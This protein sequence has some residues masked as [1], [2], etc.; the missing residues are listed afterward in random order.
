MN[1]DA[2]R[3]DH[4]AAPAPAVASSAIAIIGMAGAMPG[5]LD[6]AAYWSHLLAGDD[7]VTEVPAD[8]WDWRD[9]DGDPLGDGNRTRSRW[10]GFTP[11]VDGFD[12][13]FFGISPREAASMDPQQRLMLTAAWEAIENAGIAPAALAGRRVGVFVGAS[14]SDWK[15]NIEQ[16]GRA[17]EPHQASGTHQTMLANRISYTLDLRGPSETIDTACSSSLVALHRAVMAL[18]AG[19]VELCLAGAINLLL[20]PE[21]TI[22]YAKAGM[23]SPDGR[24]QTFDAAANGYVRSEGWGCVLLKPLAQALADGDVI[25]A[26]IRGSAENHGGRANSL[27]APNPR[28]QT[29]LVAEAVERAGVPVDSISVVEAHGTGTA[30]GDPIEINALK[31]AWRQ[32]G[33]SDRA[34]CALGA[35][36][37][38]IGHL[39]AAAGMAGLFKL[40]FA[41]Q[42]RRLPGNLHHRRTNPHIDLAGSPFELL[43]GARDWIAPEDADGMRLPLRAGVSSF[44]FG[45]VNAH[46][47]L[48]EAPGDDARARPALATAT[49]D[50]TS[51]PA[52]AQSGQATTPDDG[53][54]L[55]VLSAPDAERLRDAARALLDWLAPGS[56]STAAE[57]GRL[58]D[59]LRA[60]TARLAGLTPDA[61][62]ATL[63]FGALGL[64]PSRMARLLAGL[65]DAGA[66]GP[67]A[68]AAM[69]GTATGPA[70]AALPPRLAD[71][72]GATCLADAADA[73]ARRATRLAATPRLGASLARRLPDATGLG[74]RAALHDIA[75][76]LQT[77]RQTFDERLAIVTADRAG[78][79]A[80]LAAIAGGTGNRADA[81]AGGLDLDGAWL[82]TGS[83][84]RKAGAAGTHEAR[85]TST[86]GP[87]HDASA[88]TDALRALALRWLAEKRPRIDWTGLHAGRARHRLPLPGTPMRLVAIPRASGGGRL[89]PATAPETA[90]A[91]LVGANVSDLD[92]VAHAR[93]LAAGAAP[94]LA[95]R[96][97][98]GVLAARRGLLLLDAALS[99]GQRLGG[100]AGL[101][102]RDAVWAAPVDLAPGACLRSTWGGGRDDGVIEIGLD[103]GPLLFQAEVALGDATAA[104]AVNAAH[105]TTAS[106]DAPTLLPVAALADA[107][108]AAGCATAQPF[109][110]DSARVAPGAGSA[111]RAELR[112]LPGP[113]LCFD[114]D[115]LDAAGH[116][117]LALGGLELRLAATPLRAAPPAG[118]APEVASR[119]SAREAPDAHDAPGRPASSAATTA[120]AGA[121]DVP[122]MHAPA[123]PTT[124]VHPVWTDAGPAAPADP[125][126]LPADLRLFALDADG[127]LA[128]ELSAAVGREV[129]AIAGGLP[130]PDRSPTTVALPAALPPGATAAVVIDTLAFGPAASDAPPPAEASAAD[131]P[132]C[133]ATAARLLDLLR[134]FAAITAGAPASAPPLRLLLVTRADPALAG[135]LRG[136]GLTLAA[137]SGRLALHVLDCDAPAGAPLPVPA[138][139]AE[140][141]Q[142]CAA[143]PDAP[144]PHALPTALRH[145]AGRRE[146]IL[147][148]ATASLAGTRLAPVPAGRAGSLGTETSAPTDTDDSTA[149]PGAAPRGAVLITGGLGGLGRL[150]AR[151]LALGHGHAIETCSRSPADPALLRELADAG[152]ELRH[153]RLDITDEGALAALFADIARRHGRLAGI[154]HAAGVLRDER[155]ARQ[156]AADARAVLAPKLAGTLALDR[157]SARLR[158]D[159]VA[160]FG[161]VVGVRGNAGQG[162]YAFANG[163]LD[164][165]AHWRA[166]EVAAGRRHGATVAFDWPWWA[167]GGMPMSELQQELFLNRHGL[168]PLP[169]ARGL[170]AFDA[171]LGVALRGATAAGAAPAGIPAQALVLHGPAAAPFV[172]SARQPQAEEALS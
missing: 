122:G 150:F 92:T 66:D 83:P 42:A 82:A 55:I 102:A 156:P 99:L 140:L 108:A 19:E 170:A 134:A 75:W 172:I 157:A 30:L 40:V 80:A 143:A 100:G 2:P 103:D 50:G 152:I 84:R 94:W 18:R 89:L 118:H 20:E 60:G 68:G 93:P 105:A 169:A 127:S 130:A 62:D 76:T 54:A 34:R 31:A 29:A 148:Q 14:G 23:L 111:T 144:P 161:S 52:P 98:D 146:R 33:A 85:A 65:G 74:A 160:L 162:A 15:A 21:M 107:F 67:V 153:H 123:T 5:S 132:G 73:L 72:G 155:F 138:L 49:P 32:L 128:R 71:L 3:D 158:L 126:A 7:L 114:I 57:R 43:T 81:H 101:V 145:R 26:I 120:A 165:F 70:T 137:E 90:F 61:I 11:L 53:P 48:E 25:H 12:A 45:G 46:V 117:V 142:A 9:F 115:C 110:L 163:W 87:A 39:E 36:K 136:L 69:A 124:V 38:S 95:G 166:A 41:M 139:L 37:S 112:R 133:V 56:G 10:G 113:G 51:T 59:A 141:G 8:R 22:Q 106:T 6:L 44:G 104:G 171:A 131:G 78:L 35:V 86:D 79:V 97:A 1:G 151:H 63:P 58:L 96:P 149:N 119:A 116:L 4:R 147:W 88:T 28:A 168:L 16:P 64:S 91:A 27:T 47:V 125:P 135:A 154:V 13:A 24:C 167:E 121:A 159:F 77:G 17:R 129:A 109:R 164:G